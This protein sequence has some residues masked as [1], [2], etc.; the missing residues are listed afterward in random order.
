M[1]SAEVASDSPSVQMSAAPRRSAANRLIDLAVGAMDLFH[2]DEIAY[3][4]LSVDGHRET[5]PV[6]SRWIRLWLRRQHWQQFGEAA[7]Q[8]A[9][10]LTLD[11]L[12]AIATDPTLPARQVFRR[13]ASVGDKLYLDL[14]NAGWTCVEIDASGW[15]V[16]SDGPH[17]IRSRST[18]SLPTPVPTQTTARD[19]LL[20]LRGL[21]NLSEDD[22]QLVVAWLLTALK[23]APNYPVLVIL[24]EHG[25][26]KNLFA[27]SKN[28]I[29]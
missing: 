2:Y 18:R 19:G 6:R 26:A 20:R 28:M 11:A 16:V 1:V 7:R 27:I 3:A 5:N 25:S 21:V 22:F 15:R 13:V 9:I 10:N 12:E 14:S 23:D 29:S 24:G 4:A 17:F 8:A